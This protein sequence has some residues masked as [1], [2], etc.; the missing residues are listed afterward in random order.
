MSLPSNA[1]FNLI[2]K[3]HTGKQNA[4]ALAKRLCDV[5]N[6]AVRR[7][8]D[9]AEIAASRRSACAL[10]HVPGPFSV[11]AL[12]KGDFLSLFRGAG[13]DETPPTVPSR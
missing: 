2:D 7:R 12:K 8:S 13:A 5:R 4:K 11:P 1:R 3:E 6:R 10:A 9:S